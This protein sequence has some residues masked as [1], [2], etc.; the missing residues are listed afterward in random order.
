MAPGANILLVEASNSSLPSLQAAVTYAAN[1]PGV[2]AVSMSWGDSES[3][4]EASLDST[5][6]TP[7]GHDG[8]TFVAG[9]TGDQGGVISYPA[10][11]P[12]VVGVGGTTLSLDSQGNYLSESAWSDGGGGI[13]QYEKQPAYQNG[14]VTQSSTQRTSP[15]RRLRRQPQQRGLDLRYHGRPRFPRR[16]WH[17]PRHAHDGRLGGDR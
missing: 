6:V 1:Q 8:I 11:S 10:V 9:A 16:G 15:G 14:V 7:A 5:Y 3:F 13:S 2:V 12:N 4:D 17:Q